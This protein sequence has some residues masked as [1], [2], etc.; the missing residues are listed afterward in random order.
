MEGLGV[1]GSV[2]AIGRGEPRRTTALRSSASVPRVLP[3]ARNRTA[4]S[5]LR[6]VTT[7]MPAASQWEIR[8]MEPF[9]SRD[10]LAVAHLGANFA[11]R[12]EHRPHT[13]AQAA[14][15]PHAAA[16]HY[17]QLA[18]MRQSERDRS[19]AEATGLRGEIEKLRAALDASPKKEPPVAPWESDPEDELNRARSRVAQLERLNMQLQEDLRTQVRSNARLTRQVEHNI[20][21][22]SKSQPQHGADTIRTSL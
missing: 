17:D 18:Q 13:V 10:P 8:P 6:P 14:N 9:P 1:S 12:V 7:T 19:A 11:S 16:A 20:A 2:G 22:H 15:R 3:P 21:Q 4:P 5:S